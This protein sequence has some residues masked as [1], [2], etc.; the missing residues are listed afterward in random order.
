MPCFVKAAYAGS[1]LVVRVKQES[2]LTPAPTHPIKGSPPIPSLKGG[3]VMN[4]F[5]VGVIYRVVGGRGIQ[6]ILGFVKGFN[7]NI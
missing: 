4:P 2:I 3:N 7:N 5:I 6:N 1:N